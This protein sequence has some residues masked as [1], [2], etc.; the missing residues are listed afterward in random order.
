MSVTKL[1]RKWLLATFTQHISNALRPTV[2][3]S[4]KWEETL[5]S[6]QSEVMAA[7]SK[8]D[9]D[10]VEVTVGRTSITRDRAAVVLSWNRRGSQCKFNSVKLQ[11]DPFGW[12]DTIFG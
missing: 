7:L 3:V 5:Y 8:V 6:L 11:H 12:L 10:K 9:K 1:R 2:K 4:E